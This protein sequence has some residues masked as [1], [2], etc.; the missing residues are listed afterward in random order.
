MTKSTTATSTV[1]AFRHLLTEYRL[2][3]QVVSYN[4]PQFTSEEFTNL[5]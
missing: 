3:E 4:A 5:G 2:P 1:A